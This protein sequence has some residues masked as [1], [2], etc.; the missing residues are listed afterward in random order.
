MLNELLKQQVKDYLG[1][2]R[3]L[4]AEF[5]LFL[6]AISNTYNVFEAKR[7]S[8]D[9]SNDTC[10]DEMKRLNNKLIGET[11]ELKKAHSELGRILSSVNLGFFSRDMVT[12]RYTY[13]SGACESLYGYT[14]EEFFYNP[15]LW[16]EVI[17]PEDKVIVERDNERLHNQEE[18]HTQYRII[19]KDQS[20]RWLEFKII[21]HF[22]DGRLT[23]IDGV[24]TDIT[25]RKQVE[26]ERELMIKEL[27]K[28]NTDLKQFSFITSHNLRA[29]LSNIVGI[30]NLLDLSEFDNHNREMMKML[31][32]SVQQLSKTIDDLTKILII[33]NNTNP[34]LCEVN[35]EEVFNEVSLTF[36][37][38]LSEVD[39]T[40]TTDFTCTTTRL[41]KV[42]LESIFINLISNAIRYRASDRYLHIHVSSARDND[43]N[44][45]IRFTDNGTGIDLKRHKDRVFGLYQRF[46]TNVEGQ[47]LGLFIMKAQIEA[48][49]GK[50]DIESETDKGTTF[51]VTFKKQAASA[52]ISGTAEKLLV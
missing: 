23:R 7:N 13:L 28:S 4:P 27:M 12:D 50:I 18:L 43:G 46:H 17:H 8:L 39:A 10:S 52:G 2:E 35:I 30:L 36:V 47:G 15:K 34:D 19:H 22:K 44:V 1:E 3:E 26:T 49:G 48:T 29:P 33:R 38:A 5:K 24:V 20:V 42:Y 21:P 37:N 9:C 45:V 25:T 32:V 16:Y 51:I 31:E 14:A 40:L 6:N 11:L 41:N